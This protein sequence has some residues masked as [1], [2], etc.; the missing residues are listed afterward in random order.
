[1]RMISRRVD[2]AASPAASSPMITIVRD[3]VR[4]AWHW[5]DFTLLARVLYTVWFIGVAFLPMPLAE[6]L[7]IWAIDPQKR[8]QWLKAAPL[9]S[10]ARGL[11]AK[12]SRKSILA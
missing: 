12:R 10:H 2:K 6:R 7:I 8:P 1:M 4:S 9:I 3:G 5:P 11:A